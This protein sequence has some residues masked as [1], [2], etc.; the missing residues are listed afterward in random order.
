M[1][2]RAS[3]L[4]QTWSERPGV[5]DIHTAMMRLTLQIIAQ[6]MFS[7]DSSHMAELVD[8]SSKLYQGDMTFSPLAVLPVVR[9]GWK[10]YSTYRGKSIIRE[11]DVAIYQLIEARLNAKHSA[12]DLLDELVRA[13]DVETGYR[14]SKE[15]VR[16]QVV[17]IFMAG[18][19]T[20]ALTL[21]WA[22][23]LLA[24]HPEVQ[25]RAS[26]EVRDAIG[27]REPTLSD[28]SRMPFLRMVI[29]ETLRLYPPIH[30]LGW[31]EA[32]QD[33]SIRGLHIR[34]GSAVLISPWILHRHRQLW[35]EPERFDPERF[36]PGRVADRVKYSY[37]PFS[38]GPRVCVAPIFAI[39]E[40][41]LIL[42]RILRDF[43]LGEFTETI[44]P[45]ALITLLP[46]RTVNIRIEKRDN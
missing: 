15:E 14:L 30:T 18:H 9:H 2:D 42:S 17:T 23:Y 13:V 35:S 40:A 45:K 22:L 10:S 33:I 4:C 3:E 43:R 27:D 44:P 46:S 1:V 19:E 41:L 36:H 39:T 29:D 11:L 20:T 24:K 38:A 31:R 8:R 6:T 21:T 16:D 25:A 5:V 26:A 34:K 12:G 37:I 7:T 32:V 28:C